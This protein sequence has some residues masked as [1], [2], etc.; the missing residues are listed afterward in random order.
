MAASMT[1][2]SRLLS[3]VEEAEVLTKDLGEATSA[4][5]QRVPHPDEPQIMEILM[6]KNE[7][8]EA[9]L[10]ETEEQRKMKQEIEGLQEEVDKRDEDIKTLQKQLKEAEYI[11]ATAIYQ[12]KEK[13]KA[14]KQAKKGAISSEELIKYAHR[15]SATNAVAAPLAWE[16]GDPRRPYPTD[17]E[18]RM[19][20]LGRLSNLPQVGLNGA[21]GGD[22]AQSTAG[23]TGGLTWKPSSELTA[24]RSMST[25]VNRLTGDG[26]ID[27]GKENEDDVEMMSS[28]S[29]SSSSSDSF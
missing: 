23:A 25:G 15:I 26:G 7:E 3:L 17:L 1:A 5:R 11:L 24:S 10:K 6:K 2:K 20:V 14:I 28:D 4:V 18:M 19:G 22:G 12:A 16:P 8:L 29:E 9:T 13:L 21:G 27:L